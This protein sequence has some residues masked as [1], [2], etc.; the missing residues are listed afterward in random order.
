MPN[1]HGFG[2]QPEP[3]PQLARWLT[4]IEEFDYEVI[5]RDGKRHQN[6]DGLS[7]SPESAATPESPELSDSAESEEEERVLNVST[8]RQTVKTELLE[9]RATPSVGKDLAEQQ[10]ADPEL[11]PLIKLRH[12]PEQKP[13]I[14]PNCRPNQKWLNGC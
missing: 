10:Q 14:I 13:T 4:L 12:R 2:V 3:M 1:Y 8:V 7:R 11:G 5:H 9:E 6:A